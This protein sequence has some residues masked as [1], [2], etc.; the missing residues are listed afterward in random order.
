M[1]NLIILFLIIPLLV[2]GCSGSKQERRGI[3]N[4][5]DH[6]S[7]LDEIDTSMI[8]VSIKP[9]GYPWNE[10]GYLEDKQ[11]RK[12]DSTLI[13]YPNPFSPTTIIAIQLPADTLSIFICNTNESSCVL[14][15][16]RYFDQGR[17]TLGVQKVQRPGIYNLKI[18]GS[19]FE[20][21]KRFIFSKTK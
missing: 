13:N 14:L 15:E 2:I 18:S 5:N 8:M 19:D 10:P 21:K 16:K 4:N 3:P 9:E 12:I 17:Y 1:K 11:R 6:L 20:Y 7:I